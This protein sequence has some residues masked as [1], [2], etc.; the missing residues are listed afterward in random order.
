MYAYCQ[1]P[2]TAVAVV[3][4]SCS[5]SACSAS[6]VEG[7]GVEL[8][9]AMESVIVVV[10]RPKENDAASDQDHWSLVDW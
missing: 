5:S 6:S 9:E 7:I 1:G 10:L 2:R 3:I 4:S 8:S